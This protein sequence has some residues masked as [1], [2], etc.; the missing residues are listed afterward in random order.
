MEPL[1]MLFNSF[2]FVIFFVI[3]V[4]LYYSFKQ[5]TIQKYLLLTASYIFYGIWNP[6]FVL[7]LFYSTYI[8]WIAGIKIHS[9]TDQKVRRF[10]LWVSLCGNL[11]ILI[12]FK[13]GA[14]LLENFNLL[15][16][17][18]GLHLEYQKPNIILPLGISFYTFQTLSYTLDIYKKNLKPAKSFLDFAFF[19]TFFPQLVAGPIVRAGDFIPQCDTPK[20]A[21]KEEF[22]WGLYLITLGLFQKMVIAD[23]LL[24][25][26]T[27]SI[28]L[29]DKIILTPLDTIITIFATGTQLFFDFSGYSTCAIGA[30]LC[31]G[32]SLK[33]NFK[34]PFGS[35]G[36]FDLWRRWHISLSTLLRD[37]VYKPNGKFLNFM[38]LMFIVGLWHGASWAF[39]IWGLLHGLALSI[40]K[41]LTVKLRNLKLSQIKIVNIILNLLTVLICCS[42]AVFFKSQ[43]TKNALR[44]LHPS[45]TNIPN[46]ISHFDILVVTLI[47]TLLILIHRYMRNASLE[48][49]MEKIPGWLIVIFWSFMSIGIILTQGESD[50]FIYF[51]F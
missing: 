15:V 36:V 21:T 4:A 16:G 19:V 49:F 11:G 8:D 6:P 12:F 47:L 24:A 3:T 42:I 28:Y 25:P 40:E 10:W 31:F 2:T 43:N 33:D 14:F 17:L 35:V 50:A 1:I 20:K 48:Y 37:Y 51:Q 7:L 22:S 13:Y 32:F 30:A 5:W 18:F 23:L 45:F 46:A 44:V 9:S 39:I 34:F 38:L 41:F 27:D 26:V 29:N